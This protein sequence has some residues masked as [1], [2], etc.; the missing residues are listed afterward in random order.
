MSYPIPA[1]VPVLPA[2]RRRRQEDLPE[3]LAYSFAVTDGVHTDTAALRAWLAERRAANTFSVERVSLDDLDGWS[4]DPATGNLRHHTGRFFTIE[5]LH[6]RAEPGHWHEWHQPI[7]KQPEVGILGILVKEFDGVLHCLMQAKMEPGNPNLLQLS[8]TVQATRSNYTR[9]H[10]GAAVKYLDYFVDRR[11][12]TVLA[13]VL[14]SEHGSWF[15]RKNNRNMIVETDDDV[16]LDEDFRWVTF[17]QLAE[18]LH[19]DNVVNMDARTVLSCLPAGAARPGGATGSFTEALLRNGQEEA[20][21]SDVEVQSWFTAERSRYDVHAERVPLAGL[22]GWERAADDIRHVDERYFRVV[23]V[24]VVAG[25]RE[26]KSWSQPLIEPIG[27]GVVA[28]LARRFGG[29]PHVLV[30]AKLEAGF[31]DVVELA[32][33]VQCIPDNYPADGYRPPFLDVV[34]NADPSQVHYSVVHSEEGGRFLR[35]ESRCMIVE[36]GEEQA[37]LDPPPGFCWATPAQ[38]SSLVRHGHYLNVQA[39]TLLACLNGMAAVTH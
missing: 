34:L 3:R 30:C 7:I 39:R 24:S 38:L 36:V 10:L 29:V 26:V 1:R 35:A 9:V 21:L 14:Q 27:P 16:E 8:P 22:P 31:A 2:L 23:G 13:D 33:T 25:N 19:E 11:R 6:V 18:L 5:G 37:P 15:Y 20:L 32:P 28:F 12:A 17:G 4:S